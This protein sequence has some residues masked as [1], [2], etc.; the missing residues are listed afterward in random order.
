MWPY[1]CS[2][3]WLFDLRYLSALTPLPSLC[4]PL[5]FACFRNSERKLRV[6]LLPVLQ[7]QNQPL[8]PSDMFCLENMT[9]CVSSLWET[10]LIPVAPPWPGAEVSTCPLGRRHFNI[11]LVISVYRLSNAPKSEQKNPWAT[12]Y[13][14]CQKS[15]GCVCLPAT[16]VSISQAVSPMHI[17]SKVT[18][19]LSHEMEVWTGGAGDVMGLGKVLL[20]MVGSKLVALM[21]CTW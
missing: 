11:T 18:E 21:E 8:S 1:R 20:V 7:A 5:S 17:T 6:Y 13:L 19:V 10:K 3:L 15:Q 2:F 12:Q 14:S 16:T 4:G 9:L